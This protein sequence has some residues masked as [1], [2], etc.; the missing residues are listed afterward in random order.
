MEKQIQVIKANGDI[1]VLPSA[2]S[3]EQMEKL[4]GGDIEHVKVLDRIDDDGNFVYTSMYVNETGLHDGLPRNPKATEIYQRNIRAQYPDSKTPF[5]DAN[6]ALPSLLGNVEVI[7]NTPKEAQA[8]GY[9]N[10]PWIAGDAVYFKGYTCREAERA[11]DETRRRT[12]PNRL[13]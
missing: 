5:S 10:D 6:D 1:T 3:V 8:A 4:V 7:D 9:D 11:M 2:P 12:S 13:R